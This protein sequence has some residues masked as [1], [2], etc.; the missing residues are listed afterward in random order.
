MIAPSILSLSVRLQVEL[1][2]LNTLFPEIRR[3]SRDEISYP[4]NPADPDAEA[5]LTALEQTFSL[6]DW[7]AEETSTGSQ[8]LFGQLEQCWLQ[9]DLS[10]RFAAIPAVWLDAIVDQAKQT[11]E[12]SV[13]VAGRVCARIVPRLERSRFAR[14]G[15]SLCLCHAGWFGFQLGGST[16]RLV[17]TV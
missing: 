13:S 1:E 6:D 12:R 7:S 2:L 10:L 16:R 3:E 15:T 17:G 8:M 9:T 4:W 14:S 11:L 5:C